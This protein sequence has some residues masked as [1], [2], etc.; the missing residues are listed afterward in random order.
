M[1]RLL[2]MLILMTAAS[3][4]AISH[5]A[6]SVELKVTGVIRPVACNPTLAA[7][8]VVDYGNISATALRQG[9]ATVLPARQVSLI[10]SCNAA[11]KIALAVVDNR[12]SS[13]LAGVTDSIQP[14]AD[15]NFG[16]GL[17]GGKKIGGY[18]LSFENGATADGRGVSGLVSTDRGNSWSAGASY[19]QHEGSY[20]SFSDNGAN[21]TMQK[22]LSALI[23]VQAVLN[24]AEELPLTQDVLLDGS[25]TIEVKYL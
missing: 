19:I 9:Q 20:Y 14:G 25:A 18:V 10:V 16:L 15:Y 7:D 17:A 8:G 22:V 4:A 23:K 13:R 11:A 12:S 6:P 5:A 3:A 24:K 1:K 21:P 2:S